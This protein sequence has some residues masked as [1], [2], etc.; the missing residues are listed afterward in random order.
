MQRRCANSGDLEYEVSGDQFS[1]VHVEDPSYARRCLVMVAPISGRSGKNGISERRQWSVRYLVLRRV[2]VLVATVVPHQVSS[3]NSGNLVAHELYI[4]FRSTFMCVVRPMSKRGPARLVSLL[5]FPFQRS[6]YRALHF[7]V[8]VM[9][10]A[11]CL[12]L[13]ELASTREGRGRFEMC[14]R[15]GS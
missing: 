12:G 1:T 15:R 8:C 9:T 14:W 10:P 13:T 3:R 11:Q 4:K 5:L 6:L 7:L 2:S